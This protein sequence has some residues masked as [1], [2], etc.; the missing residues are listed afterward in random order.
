MSVH[1]IYGLNFGDE[2]MKKLTALTSI[3]ALVSAMGGASIAVAAP[4]GHGPAEKATVL[5]CGCNLAGTDMVYTEISINSKSRG[6]DAHVATTIDS[7]FDG[8]DTYTDVV[9]IGDDC[10]LTGPP[11]GD[12]I[13]ECS[14]MTT[15][16]VAG[17]DC[18][19]VM[20]Q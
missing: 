8:A 4:N 16:P 17:D 10:Q 18:G 7:C 3:I 9:R 12:P 13:D 14:S 15:P 5:H 2:T 19:G 1:F 20:I 11:L 6:H